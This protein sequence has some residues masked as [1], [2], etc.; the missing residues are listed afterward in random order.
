MYNRINY[1]YD[2]LIITS[3]KSP[4]AFTTEIAIMD[5]TAKW[6]TSSCKDVI[7]LQKMHI[8]PVCTYY[9]HAYD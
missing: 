6:A 4:H 2:L 8:G 3:V 9:V 7:Q 5:V 1:K